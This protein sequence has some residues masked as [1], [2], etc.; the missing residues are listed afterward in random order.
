MR[1]GLVG[2]KAQLNTRLECPSNS[3]TLVPVSHLQ[4]TKPS[5]F[6]HPSTPKK[7]N[8]TRGGSHSHSHEGADEGLALAI[9]RSDDP[10]AVGGPLEVVDAAGEDAELVLEDVV[11]AAAPD[12]DSTGG[13]GGGHPLAVGGEA[14]DAGGVGVLGV[15]GDVEGAVEVPDDHG[16]A[17]AVGDGVRFRV[18]GDQDATAALRRRRA[19]V[20]FLQ[21]R[22]K[23]SV[24][25][26]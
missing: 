10:E 4:Q 21:Q 12:A 8:K 26:G 9:T 14:G 5:S 20:D 23:R 15:H 11:R 7:Q 17:V 1:K 3:P 2:L 19:G 18:T 13:V 16:P 25:V 24:G 22:H 6:N